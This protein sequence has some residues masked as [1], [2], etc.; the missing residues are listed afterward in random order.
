MIFLILGKCPLAHHFNINCHSREFWPL[1]TEYSTSLVKIRS[2][3]KDQWIYGCDMQETRRL[4]KWV[5]LK[6][7][8]FNSGAVIP[9]VKKTKN[10]KLWE[11]STLPYNEATPLLIKLMTS[12]ACNNNLLLFPLDIWNKPLNKVFWPVNK[13]NTNCFEHLYEENTDPSVNV[14]VSHA[15]IFLLR[16]V[17]LWQSER[18]EWRNSNRMLQGCWCSWGYVPTHSFWH[19]RVLLKSDLRKQQSRRDMKN[20]IYEEWN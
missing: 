20:N 5:V 8:A 17:W 1:Y 6:R 2:Y 13:Q 18:E 10:I 12:R 7:L 3:F 16:F 9:Y 14:S 15:W 4:E 11:Y 19:K